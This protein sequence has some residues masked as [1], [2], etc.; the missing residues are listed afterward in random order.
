MPSRA[1]MLVASFLL[2]LLLLPASGCRM[3]AG[4]SANAEAAIN[5]YVQARLHIDAGD[6]DAALAE[7][8]AA[9]KADPTLSIAH[10]TAGD[11]YRQKGDWQGAR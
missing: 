6:L 4:N 3:D 9:V 7:L 2:L 10:A 5:Q 8:A 11:I 1:M